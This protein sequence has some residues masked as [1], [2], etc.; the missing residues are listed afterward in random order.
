MTDKS[1]Q[2]CVRSFRIKRFLTAEWITCF[3][4]GLALAATAIG[5][6]RAVEDTKQLRTLEFSR[7]LRESAHWDTAALVAERIKAMDREIKTIIE[8]GL[9]G[10]C[11]PG[12]LCELATILWEDQYSAAYADTYFME[13]VDRLV[14]FLDDMSA[15][16]Q[17]NLC[18]EEVAN[19][20]FFDLTQNSTNSLGEFL[21]RRRAEPGL[22]SY[23]ACLGALY[24]R[25][26]STKT[27]F[28]PRLRGG[29]GAGC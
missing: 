11:E 25:W 21:K 29:S 12:E 8:G 26:Q 14:G 9:R 20:F 6:W 18:D 13:R 27:T 10:A 23:G 15:C 3:I 7:E 5:Y 17:Y 2:A 16:V 1:V 19:I 24:E 28:W 22:A 4:A